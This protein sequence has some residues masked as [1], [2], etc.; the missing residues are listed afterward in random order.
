[1]TTMNCEQERVGYD[2]Q[3]NIELISG[4]EKFKFEKNGHYHIALPFKQDPPHLPYS[5]PTVRKRL[6]YLKSIIERDPVLH[7]KYSKVMKK[8][9][10][11]RAAREVCDDELANIKPPWYQPY[12]AVWQPKEPEEP[13][14]VFDCG[15][16]T[17]EV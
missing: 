5:L 14:V 12:H 15:S 6:E 1:M 9:D 8:Y 16:K 11:E 17:E 4:C 10:E 13:R 7:E 2:V 3:L